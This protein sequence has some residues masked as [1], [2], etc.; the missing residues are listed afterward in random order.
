MSDYDERQEA[1]KKKEAEREATEI[2]SAVKLVDVHVRLTGNIKKTDDMKVKIDNA[3]TIKV[4][5]P[6]DLKKG[7][8]I[9][10]TV[11]RVEVPSSLW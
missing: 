1:W 7:D 11:Q 5:P 2:K 4:K 6:I 8:T 10:V 9:K 3:E